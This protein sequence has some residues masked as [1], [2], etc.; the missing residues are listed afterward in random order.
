MTSKII[1]VGAGA[2]SKEL[3][4]KLAEKKL[5]K[6][7]AIIDTGKP[8]PELTLNKET[9]IPE[10]TIIPKIKIKKTKQIKKKKRKKTKKQKTK[11]WKK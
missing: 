8:K 10:K 9:F 7:I 5:G 3:A 1:I 2:N 4:K 6:E 11:K